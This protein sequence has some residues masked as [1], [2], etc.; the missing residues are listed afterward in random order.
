[1]P[2][3]I[4]NKLIICGNNYAEF[5]SYSEPY[6]IDF[7]AKN[8]KTGTYT[9]EQKEEKRKNYQ[10][11]SKRDVKRMAFSNFSDDDRTMLITLTYRLMNN[12]VKQAK[13]DIANWIREVNRILNKFGR[14]TAKY[15]YKIEFQ[16]RGHI[17]FHILAS[18]IRGFPW[19]SSIA[20]LWRKQKTLPSSWKDTYNLR[21]IWINK[22]NDN[23]GV[24]VK[25]LKENLKES[26]LQLTVSYVTKY[27]TKEE[28]K[29][30]QGERSFETSRNLIKPVVLYNDEATEQLRLIRTKLK[31]KSCWTGTP[32]ALLEI[33]PSQEVT[34]TTYEN[35]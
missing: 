12:S 35:T 21:D 20:T 27:M 11:I 15:I 34:I 33:K 17:H 13:V 24:D 25:S 32:T 19:S 31:E 6:L 9:A 14:P 26:S 1:M 18:Q 7:S 16:K 8:K 2:K 4:Q 5:H 22:S 30:M 29:R 3:L 10:R 23:G 28:D